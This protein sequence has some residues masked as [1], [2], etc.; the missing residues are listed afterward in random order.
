MPPHSLQAGREQSSL[1]LLSPNSFFRRG[2]KGWPRASTAELNAQKAAGLYPTTYAQRLSNQLNYSKTTKTFFG[3]SGVGYS[4]SAEEAATVCNFRSDTCPIYH[5]FEPATS[6]VKVW[7]VKEGGAEEEL[8]P[9]GAFNN[10]QSAIEAVPMPDPTKLLIAI[11]KTE[12][13]E[14][15]TTIS[16]A[17][18][19]KMVTIVDHVRD[20]I[21]EFHRLRKF[22]SGPHTGEWKCG[23]AGVLN[24]AS[25]SLGVYPV[26]P[27]GEAPGD[28]QPWGISAS[29]LVLPALTITLQDIVDVLRG[30]PIRHALGISVGVRGG[31][32]EPATK[33]DSGNLSVPATHGGEA[34]PAYATAAPYP[35]EIPEGLAVC[36]PEGSEPGEHGITSP[37]ASAVYRALRDYGGF[38]HDGAGATTFQIEDLRT[39]GSPYTWI[40]SN[41]FYGCTS[42]GSTATDIAAYLAA[43]YAAL[44]GG[45]DDETLPRFY[46]DFLS[47]HSIVFNQPWEALE[48][49]QPVSS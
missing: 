13:E 43:F 15:I 32:I 44:P 26:M 24:E 25:K 40:R 31:S 21:Y 3:Y 34:N 29:G 47:K 46:E 22:V 2:T 8:R 16:A 6:L 27:P 28:G 4:K 10:M 36:Y 17:G 37:L 14:G 23:Y 45:W 39:I 42:I 18:T 41:P 12:E 11:T 5:I 38:V 48:Q 7:F 30:K 20:T 19:D 9:E 1:R 35:D 49:L 33:F